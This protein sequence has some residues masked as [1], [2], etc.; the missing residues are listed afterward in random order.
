MGTSPHSLSIVKKEK[1]RT[2]L[3]RDESCGTKARA[4]SRKKKANVG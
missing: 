3:N 1:E 4:G 2:L